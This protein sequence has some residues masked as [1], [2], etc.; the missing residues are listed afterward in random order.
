L[1]LGVGGLGLSVVESSHES[2]D[3][4][5]ELGG[6]SWVRAVTGWLLTIA[7]G[8]GVVWGLLGE[9]GIQV[10]CKGKAGDEERTH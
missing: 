4:L 8:R 6:R 3:A 1:R 7:S 9:S 5:C 2:A 10:E